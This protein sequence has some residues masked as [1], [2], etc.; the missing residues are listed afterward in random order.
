R[1]TSIEGEIVSVESSRLA[2]A[3]RIAAGKRG[4]QR[5]RRGTG[6][7]AWFF[8]VPMLAFFSFV[9]VANARSVG[10]P[11]YAQA[12]DKLPR[13]GPIV[14]VKSTDQPIVCSVTQSQAAALAGQWQMGSTTMSANG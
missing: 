11:D 3:Q 2:A 9:V 13:L 10:K 14:L 8:I 1:T 12:L 7:A 6:R 5:R 4:A